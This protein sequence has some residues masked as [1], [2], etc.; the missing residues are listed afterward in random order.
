M[1]VNNTFETL[2][3]NILLILLNDTIE[4]VL[5]KW[6]G[7][8]YIYSNQSASSRDHHYQEKNNLLHIL[9]FCKKDFLPYICLFIGSPQIFMFI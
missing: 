9:W 5:H 4:K 1:E 6:F 8:T 2:C 7:A 3:T